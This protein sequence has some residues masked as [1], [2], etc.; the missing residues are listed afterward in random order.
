[1]ELLALLSEI[2][3]PIWVALSS[4]VGGLGAW[5]VNNRKV[6]ASVE[7]ARIKMVADA[8]V[9]ENAER[10][11]FR[12]TLMGDIAAL[13]SLIKECETE[14]DSLRDRIN[15]AEGQ[16]VVLKASNEIM[17]RWVAFFKERSAPDPRPS[18]KPPHAEDPA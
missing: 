14:K 3:T 13:R 5:I 7:R 11:A 15:R 4:A 12:A 16:I 6:S 9:G 17:E 1:L 2:S 18:G 8:A 10:T